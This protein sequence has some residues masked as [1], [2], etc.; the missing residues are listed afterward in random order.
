MIDRSK[1]WK[2]KIITPTEE[3]ATMEEVFITRAVEETEACLE[4]YLSLPS[5]MGGHYINSDLF[6]EV[7]PEYRENVET[8]RK[9]AEVVHN[10]AAVLANE[11]FIRN[12]RDEKV[13]ECIFLTGVPG[14]GKTFFIQSLYLS[15]QV[16]EDVMIYEGD[17]TNETIKEK[18]R[19]VIENNK[20]VHIIVIN[21]T[22]EL[23]MSNAINRALEIGR[24]ASCATIA[25]IMSSLPMA[26]DD[27]IRMCNGNLSLGIY[28]KTAN[29]VIE[30]FVGFDN[31]YLLECGTYDEIK[32]RLEAIR[33][34]ILK[35]K[36]RVMAYQTECVS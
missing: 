6:K 5:S 1:I 27:I 34:E 3:Q 28:N 24:G 9:Y 30:F 23:A 14:A 13:K 21:P 17:I 11:M 29:D 20:R 31:L 4:S 33:L 7:F 12:A 26:L 10:S 8:R 16:P 2:Q 15:G 32:E 36:R 19:L 25:R 35:K 22:L 18:I